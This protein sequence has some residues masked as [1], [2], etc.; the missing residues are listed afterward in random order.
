VE[1][2]LTTVAV[3]LLKMTAKEDDREE[4]IREWVQM[5]TRVE[6][7]TRVLAPILC[8]CAPHCFSLHVRQ[9]EQVLGMGTQRRCQ[10]RS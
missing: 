8:L 2:E 4:F 9:L 3:K 5:S 7:S 1:G 10:R 6:M